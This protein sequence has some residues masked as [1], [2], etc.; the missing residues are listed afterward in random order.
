MMLAQ[1]RT[2][3]YFTDVVLRQ[4]NDPGYEV[5]ACCDPKKH[6]RVAGSSDTRKD[7]QTKLYYFLSSVL[8]QQFNYM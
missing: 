7:R 1:P 3:A 8:I 4:W 6:P 2:Q 5:D